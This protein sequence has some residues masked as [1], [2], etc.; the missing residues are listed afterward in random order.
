MDGVLRKVLFDSAFPLL[1]VYS[2][3]MIMYAHSKTCT[4]MFLTVL[5]IIARNNNWKI[6]W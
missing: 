6:L 4:Q 3:N 2:R 5:F 1:D